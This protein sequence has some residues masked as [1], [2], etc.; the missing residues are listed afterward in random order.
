MSPYAVPK[1]YLFC[2]FFQ[3]VLFALDG[4]T[5]RILGVGCH[6]K[7]CIFCFLFF[8]PLPLLKQEKLVALHGI[9]SPFPYF[10][11]ILLSRCRDIFRFRALFFLLCFQSRQSAVPSSYWHSAITLRWVWSVTPEMSTAGSPISHHVNL[12]FSWCSCMYIK[13]AYLKR[14][15]GMDTQITWRLLIL[16][17]FLVLSLVLDSLPCP[18]KKKIAR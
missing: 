9:F 11:G 10:S 1:F 15:I 6:R 14:G 3:H 12:E 17:R 18:V 4:T 7:P 16:H 2:L 8:F 13:L 5:K